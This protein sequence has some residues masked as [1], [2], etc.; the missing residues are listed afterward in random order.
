MG[1][2]SAGPSPASAQIAEFLLSRAKRGNSSL[3]ICL[4]AYGVGTQH[5]HLLGTLLK[6]LVALGSEIP[7]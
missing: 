7:G 1:A 6:V 5:R 4:L 2:G 3:I